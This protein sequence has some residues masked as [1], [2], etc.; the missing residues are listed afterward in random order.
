MAVEKVKAAQDAHAK[1]WVKVKA[2]AAK[3][4]RRP[5]RTVFAFVRDA[6]MRSRTSEVFRARRRSVRNA[7]RRCAAAKRLM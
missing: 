1:A 2:G 6:G 4:A 7:A 3:A 5:G